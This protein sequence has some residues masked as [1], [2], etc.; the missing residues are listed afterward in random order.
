MTPANPHVVRILPQDI[1]E[2]GASRGSI[3]FADRNNEWNFVQI[4][5]GNVQCKLTVADVTWAHDL[6]LSKN[7]DGF[8][9]TDYSAQFLSKVDFKGNVIWRLATSGLWPNYPS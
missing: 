3:M 2:I 4:S 5:S 6:L 7:R 9:V 1:P 8:I